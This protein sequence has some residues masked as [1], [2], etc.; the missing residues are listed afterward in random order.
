MLVAG[1]SGASLQLWS[2]PDLR[3]VRR[4]EMGGVGSVGFFRGG[5][6]Y[7]LTQMAEGDRHR[8]FRSWSLPGGEARTLGTVDWDGIADASIDPAGRSL[9]YASG[10][11]VSLLPF[12]DPRR[13][14][15]RVL[16]RHPDTVYLV[17]FFPGGDGVASVDKAGEIR[18]WPLDPS[19]SAPP[20]VLRG[21]KSADCLLAVDGD[22]TH[23]ARSGVA[24]SVHLWDLRD[25][26]DAEPVALKRT[27]VALQH[28]WR[29]RP[30]RPMA[31]RDERVQRRVLAGHR[32]LE[33]R[34][35]RLLLGHVAPGLH[36]RRTLAGLLHCR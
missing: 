18:L 5:S 33:A 12:D 17:E 28:V 21:P 27:E 11:S 25:P 36:P 16:G 14:V 8:L 1:G 23:L 9:A 30:E 24:G 2:L 35:A 4:V 3:E 31:G 19:A 29:L 7:T 34:A 13:D 10:H 15:G 32:T 26:P 20:R 6:L 22:A